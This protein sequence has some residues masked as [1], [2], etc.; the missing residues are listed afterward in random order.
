MQ[1]GLVEDILSQNLI[2]ALEPEAAS[3]YCR[4]LA[5]DK[6]MG[7]AGEQGDMVM[8]PGEK[9]AIVDCGGMLSGLDCMNRP[10]KC[11][12]INNKNPMG[13]GKWKKHGN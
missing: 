11:F 8:K 12:E 5:M 3:L 7:M 9:Y 10:I 2:I 6:F 1:A 4:T 13:Q